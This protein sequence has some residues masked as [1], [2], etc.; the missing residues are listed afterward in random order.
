MQVDEFSYEQ[1]FSK[2]WYKL[3]KASLKHQ[4]VELRLILW[5]VST[6]CLALGEDGCLSST[7]I[8]HTVFLISQPIH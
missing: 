3:L 5:R 6:M 8:S 1:G 7:L 4:R 2:T